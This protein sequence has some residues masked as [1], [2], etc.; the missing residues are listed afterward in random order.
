MKKLHEITGDIVVYAS[1][2]SVWD[3]L[4][5][6]FGDVNNFNPLIDESHPL[7]ENQ[8]QLGCE[9]HCT[10]DGK[11]SV[12]EKITRISGKESFDIDIIEGGLPMM[13]KMN[14]TFNLKDAGNGKTRIEFVM[15]F[16]TSPAFMAPM[17]KGMMKKQFQKLLV[18]LKYHLET[19]QLV[20]KEN[21]KDIMS[22]YNDIGEGTNF[23]FMK[24]EASIA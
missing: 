22:D 15:K 13:D 17:I 8:G 20:T 10:I 14:G 19:N 5:N 4:V 12:R 9:R 23:E 21:I 1:N 2:D 7:D 24:Q 18:G 16:N 6:K 3:L 11:N